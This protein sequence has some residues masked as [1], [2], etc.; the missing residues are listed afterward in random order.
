MS[1]LGRLILT[2][3]LTFDCPHPWGGEGTRT[4]AVYI[5]DFPEISRGKKRL[6]KEEEKKRPKIWD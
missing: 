6:K 3:A 5:T 1:P 4:K 2:H